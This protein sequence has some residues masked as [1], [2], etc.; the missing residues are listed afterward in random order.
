LRQAGDADDDTLE[1]DDSKNDMMTDLNNSRSSSKKKKY[2]LLSLVATAILAAIIG[3]GIGLAIS[4]KNDN[5]YIVSSRVIGGE[6][7]VDGRF[8]YFVTSRVYWW[9]RYS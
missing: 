9:Q 3:I 8:S 1:E 7:T 2:T 6:D 5:E 4:A